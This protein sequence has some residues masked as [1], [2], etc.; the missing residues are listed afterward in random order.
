MYQLSVFIHILSAIVWVGGMFF[1]AL[2]LVPVARKLPTADRAELLD[3]LGRRFRLVGWIAIVL[4]LATGLL[5]TAL[6]GVTWEA[7]GSGR[8]LGSWFGQVLTVKIV[9]VCL[10]LALSAVHDFA[11]GPASVRAL[12]S[13]DRGTATLRAQASWIGRATALLAVLVLA[14][15]VTLVRG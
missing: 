15:A 8:L 9:L 1:V 11:L 7:V 12:A 4:L 3:R 5:N 2:V 10:M 14:L 6:R 13:D